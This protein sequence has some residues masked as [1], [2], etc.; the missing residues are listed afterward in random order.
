[1]QAIV[2]TA[3]VRDPVFNAFDDLMRDF[4]APRAASNEPVSVKPRVDVIDRGTA[5]ELVT[6]LPGVR[7]QDIKVQIEADRISIETE[8][9]VRA[10]LKDG[11][12]LVFSERAPRRYVRSFVLP[13]EIDE[14]GAQARFEDG[15]L[16]L[17]LPKRN[18]SAPRAIVVQ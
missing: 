13:N 16:T 1:M 12:R 5:F 11:E 8:P 6:D 4:L 2:R 9:A 15:V 10:E 18:A 3:A 7:K 17:T 14:A